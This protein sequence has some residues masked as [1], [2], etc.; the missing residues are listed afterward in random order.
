MTIFLGVI[1]AAIQLSFTAPADSLTWSRVVAYGVQVIDRHG[2]QALVPAYAKASLTGGP[3]VPAMPGMDDSLF[4]W[5]SEDWVGRLYVVFSKDRAGN[6]SRPSNPVMVACGKTVSGADTIFFNVASSGVVPKW[7]HAA[8]N[9]PP[10]K[11][12]AWSLRP[13]EFKLTSDDLEL[14]PYGPVVHQETIQR[15]AT[16]YLCKTVGFWCL[17]GDT[18]KC[19]DLR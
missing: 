2:Y 19:G 14:A 7:S 18:I 5:E 15:L 16:P 17:R 10:V 13:Y 6:V 3:P 9:N 11:T 4:I 8:V 12:V 1:A